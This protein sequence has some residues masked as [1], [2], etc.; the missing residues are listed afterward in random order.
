MKNSKITKFISYIVVSAATAKLLILLFSKNHIES[1][2]WCIGGGWVIWLIFAFRFDKDLPGAGPCNY[3][4]GKN[5]EARF[6]YT[7]TVVVIFFFVV[8]FS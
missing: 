7:A 3:N 1:I 8:I 4:D 2:F 6:I 5:Q